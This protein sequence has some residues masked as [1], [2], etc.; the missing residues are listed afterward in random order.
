MPPAEPPGR[1]HL[2]GRKLRC[3]EQQDSSQAACQVGSALASACQQLA[4]GWEVRQR[5]PMGQVLA[6]WRGSSHPLFS[7]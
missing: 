2:T 4:W 5:V 6:W 1:L 3:R 7:Q